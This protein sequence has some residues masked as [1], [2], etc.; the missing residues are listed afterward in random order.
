MY[1]M[2]TIITCGLFILNLLFEGQKRFFKEVV[3][4]IQILF[5]VSIYEWFI[6]NSELIGVAVF[7]ISKALGFLQF[8]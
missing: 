4:K 5:M 3:Q 2:R 7:D 8:V 1:C 6:I